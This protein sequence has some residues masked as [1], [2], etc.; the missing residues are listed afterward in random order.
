[1]AL[2]H[3]SDLYIAGLPQSPWRVAVYDVWSGFLQ[4]RLWLYL[5]WQDIRQKYSRSVLGPFWLTLSMSV[6]I[7]M[8]AFVYGAL[9]KLPSE[10]YI[11]FLSAGLVLWNFISLL[12]LDSCNVFMMAESIIKQSRLPLTTHIFRMIARNLII[13]A[14]NLV[15]V[16]LVFIFFGKF[17]DFLDIF[18]F[19]FATVLISLNALWMALILGPICTRFRDVGQVVASFVQIVFFVTPVMWMPEILEKNRLGSYLLSLNPFTYFLDVLRGPLLGKVPG[20]FEW[21]VVI[22]CMV[23][24]FIATAFFFGRFRNRVAYWL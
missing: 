24:G 15:V 16:L 18:M 20:I 22:I 7:V 19:L 2:T 5:A 17:P 6:M 12:I 21:G 11:P 1:M 14:H 23:L 10:V 8:L 3:Q 9:F 13:L 4:Y